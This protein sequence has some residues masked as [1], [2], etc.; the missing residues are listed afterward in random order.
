MEEG[1]NRMSLATS[2]DLSHLSE[3]E[4]IRLAQQGDPA[5][6]ELLY[7]QHS[8]RVYALCFRMAGNASDA[9]DLT[10]EAFLQLFR[11]IGSFRGDSSFSTWL[12]RVTL[13]IALMRF[14]KRKL[15]EISFTDTYE[16]DD[17]SG[18]PPS[19]IGAA[20]LNLTGLVDRVGL[21]RAIDQLPPG[22]KAM[23]MLHDVQGYAH[24]EIAK[25]LGCSIGNSKSQL[26]KA[27][28]RLRQLLREQVLSGGRP[29]SRKPAS[30][31]RWALP[32]QASA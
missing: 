27:R 4:I 14:R 13:N 16:A 23:F 8:R 28:R 11:K 5:A 10:Q 25:I 21:N 26:H 17:E 15:A 32:A 6:F 22:C 18:R 2:A 24:V 19:Q 3:T 9:E 20:D 1:R 31:I 29:E 30:R 12:H 7:Q